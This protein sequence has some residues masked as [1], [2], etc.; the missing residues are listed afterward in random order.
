MKEEKSCQLKATPDDPECRQYFSTDIGEL[1]L[2]G[3]NGE[4]ETFLFTPPTSNSEFRIDR[5]NL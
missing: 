4:G 5:L 2:L 1:N 3:D